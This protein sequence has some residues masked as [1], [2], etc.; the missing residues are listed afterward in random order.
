MQIIE[1]KSLK[2]IPV[3]CRIF[4][5]SVTPEEA[6]AILKKRNTKLIYKL[7]TQIRIPI[8]PGAHRLEEG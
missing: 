6:I 5:P 8:T 7:L 4:D 3:E 1:V 2:E